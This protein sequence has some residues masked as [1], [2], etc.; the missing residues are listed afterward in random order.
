[1][2]DDTA[3][4]YVT[5]EDEM[6]PEHAASLED[7]LSPGED[8][9]AMQRRITQLEAALQARPPP[10]PG[11]TFAQASR[12]GPA[13]PRGVLFGG[14]PAS[15]HQVPPQDAVERL[16]ALA[17]VAPVRLG[18]H[19]RATREQRPERIL[20]SLQQEAG[21]EAA[22]PAELEEGI[23]ELEAAVSDP[24]QR[25]LVLQMKQMALL[26]RQQTQRQPLD[27]LAAALAG[28]SDG[29]NTG[30]GSVKG[31]AAREAYLKVMQDHGKVAMVVMDHACR[32]LGLES[33]QVG[34]GLMKEYIEKKCPLGD[35]RLLTQQAYL[36]AFAWETGFRLNDVVLMGVASRGLLF[37]DQA[38]T[39]YGK[40]N[41]AW[42]LTALPDPQFSI[43][44]RNRHRQSL[45][46][47]S[48]LASASWVG[49]NVAFMKDLDYLET[50]IKSTNN[51]S[52]TK[53]DKGGGEDTAP[54]QRKTPWK[55][56]RKKKEESDAS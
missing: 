6:W 7:P 14:L 49:A 34:P 16:R 12:S 26:T 5:G 31:C 29:Q 3:G 24:L 35:N 44:Q 18:A 51:F 13:P 8:V 10:P 55:P 50:K 27:P 42:L 46:P 45:T 33:S 43:V 32:E 17:G 38:A 23:A 39:D 11:G 20:E 28:G 4:D 40:T 21:L 41:L 37:I 36:W 47:Y 25:M 19:E 15:S 9:A 22:E 30:S 53:D 56:K 54:T 1:M 2:D 48:R 52:L